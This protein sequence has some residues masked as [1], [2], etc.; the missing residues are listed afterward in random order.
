MVDER[1][2]Y[3]GKPD[4]RLF[5]AWAIKA[6]LIL[7]V[8]ILFLA[9]MIFASTGSKGAFYFDLVFALLIYVFVLI[10]LKVQLDTYKYKI[11]DKGIYFNGGFLTKREKFVPFY[12]ITNVDVLQTFVDQMFGISRLGFQTAGQGAA[13]Y[14]EITFQGLADAKKPKEIAL[15]WIK[16]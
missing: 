4:K 10:F 8:C 12:K 1:V 13:N 15:K 16:E 14:P 3:E 11:T 9:P 2:L 5:W 7:L 6:T